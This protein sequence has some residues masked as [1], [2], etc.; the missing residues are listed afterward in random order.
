MR[1]VRHGDM[2]QAMRT[3]NRLSAK[4][5]AALGEGKF[6]D[7]RGLWLYR[8]G[9]GA[10][11]WVFRFTVHRRRREM[12][13]GA[14]P[15]VSLA[16]ARRLAEDAR[17]MA[18]LGLDPIA[19][20]ERERRDAVRSLHLLADVARDA[21]EARKAELKG[22]GMAGRWF[23]P[24]ERHVLPKLGRVPVADLDQIAIR[25]CLAPIWHTKAETAGKALYRLAIVLRHAAALGLSVDLQACDKAR[26]LLGRSRHER[27]HIPAMAWQDVPG[28]YARLADGTV[29]HLALRLLILTG[30]RSSPVRMIREGEIDGDIWTVP[31]ANMKGRKGVAT[32]FRVPLSAEALAVIEEARRHA[33][34]GFLFP[35]RGGKP[36]SDM[37]LSMA[38]RRMGL[39]ARP[40]GFRTSLRTWLAECTDAPHEVAE[41]CLAHASGSAVVRAYRRTDYLD[42]RRA[43]LTRWS[44]HVTGKGGKVIQIAGARA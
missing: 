18:R 7:G 9:R 28:F 30:L 19:E 38:M 36:I 21:F 40:H 34:G 5:V 41:T 17:A 6:G 15:G 23:S 13:L 29:T 8:D 35:G 42:Q 26:L 10:G 2:G 27:Q 22:D 3:V 31:A 20:R 44:D 16:E 1:H 11:R 4:A 14:Y 25:D 43:L 37:T 24:L 39:E 12:G 32:D 33:R